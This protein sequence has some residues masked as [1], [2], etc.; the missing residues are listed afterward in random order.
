MLLVSLRIL[1]INLLMQESILSALESILQP[2]CRFKVSI[3]NSS[4]RH[5]DI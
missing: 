5:I 4:G 3:F 1:R 2:T